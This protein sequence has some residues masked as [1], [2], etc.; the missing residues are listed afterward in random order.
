MLCGYWTDQHNGHLQVS[1]GYKELINAIGEQMR[2]QEILWTG[3][4]SRRSQMK[5]PYMEPYFIGT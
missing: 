5:F 4:G 3:E 2:P 1:S